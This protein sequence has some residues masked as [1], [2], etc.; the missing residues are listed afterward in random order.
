MDRA[1]P[2]KASTPHITASQS[3]ISHTPITSTTTSHVSASSTSQM[4]SMVYSS[5]SV[6]EELISLRILVDT[7]SQKSVVAISSTSTNKMETQTI[8]VTPLVS[9][10]LY[11]DTSP[12]SV[13]SISFDTSSSSV[14]AAIPLSS[15]YFNASPTPVAAAISTSHV[16]LE[17]SP[18]SSISVAG[19]QGLVFYVS[20]GV[21]CV[22][23]V[24]ICIIV[25]ALLTVYWSQ[26][27]SKAK[28]NCIKMAPDDDMHLNTNMMYE[29][30]NPTIV[31]HE[32][33]YDE[34]DTHT[35]CQPKLKLITNNSK[36]ISAYAVT[37][38]PNA[39]IKNTSSLH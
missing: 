5:A 6:S 18:V 31:R 22:L 35:P 8:Q 34:P 15:I 26:K 38:I 33:V 28:M 11:V 13:A 23:L 10:F 27:K 14:A 9:S 19:G 7:K 21:V 37:A 39:A 12:T 16:Y 2:I 25:V 32:H 17:I 24:L 1:P 3:P 4:M 36:S 20:L 29:S 30:A